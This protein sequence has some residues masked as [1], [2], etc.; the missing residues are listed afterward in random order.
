MRDEMV[1]AVFFDCYGVLVGRG[2][3]ETYRLAGGNPNQDNEFIADILGQANLGLID[4]ETLESRVASKLDIPKERYQE[5]ALSAEQP[6]IELL[7][8]I[9]SLRLVYKT[10]VISNV[11]RGA[12]VEKKIGAGW[13]ERCF[14]VIV[15]SGDIGLAKPS[16]EIYEVAAERL[17]VDPKE[18]VFVDDRYDYCEGA[19]DVGMQTIEYHDFMQFRNELDD[20]LN[21]TY[22]EH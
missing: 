11:S 2:F 21:S 9:A 14:D 8:Y 5:A 16:P 3:D 18:C 6:N 13:A 22:S 12:V 15:A 7:T 17:D 1:K 19:R 20:A 4:E 10:G